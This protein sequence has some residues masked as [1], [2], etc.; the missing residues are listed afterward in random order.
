MTPPPGLNLCSLAARGLWISAYAMGGEF[1]LDQLGEMIGCGQKQAEKLVAELVLR[2]CAENAENGVR[3]LGA[4]PDQRDVAA[5]DEHRRELLR[6]RQQRWRDRN[7]G[8]TQVVTRKVTEY[9]TPERNADSNERRVSLHPSQENTLTT[10][11]EGFVEF[12]ENYPRKTAKTLAVK[13]FAKLN[14]SPELLE[15]ILAA[16]AIHRETEQWRGG[17]QYIPHAATWLNQRR[18]DDEIVNNSQQNAARNG[19]KYGNFGRSF[20]QE[21]EQRNRAAVREAAELAARRLAGDGSGDAGPGGGSAGSGDD[22]PPVR[23]L[24]AAAGG[25]S[26]E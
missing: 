6:E 8:V 22:Q 7:A 10:P 12:W 24:S 20:A 16:L 4:L 26:G 17:Q 19:E 13:A 18:F 21:R 9:V 15:K 25:D 1:P 3:M 14:P 2:R 23:R 11:P 5:A